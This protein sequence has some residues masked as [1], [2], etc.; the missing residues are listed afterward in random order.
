MSN[1]HLVAARS[2]IDLAAS[3]GIGGHLAMPPLPHHRAYD[4]KHG[5]FSREAKAERS[6][7]RAAILTVRY[8]RDSI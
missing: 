4:W 1:C 3:I 8:L 7:V 2:L 5:H 6:R